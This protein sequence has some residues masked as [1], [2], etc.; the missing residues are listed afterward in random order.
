MINAKAP[1]VANS[2]V[3]ASLRSGGANVTRAQIGKQTRYQRWK[4]R[5]H[6]DPA[7]YQ[8]WLDYHSRYKRERVV[9][10]FPLKAVSTALSLPKQ[11]WE[12]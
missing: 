12:D 8:R 3:G 9:S 5:L 11:P 7:R 10:I 6:A 1:S 2:M 4:V